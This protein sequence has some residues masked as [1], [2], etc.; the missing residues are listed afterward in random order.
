[1]KTSPLIQRFTALV[2][3]WNAAGLGEQI[4]WEVLEGLRERPFPFLPPLPEEDLEMC[5]A[6]RDDLKMWPFWDEENK[7]WLTVPISSWRLIRTTTDSRQLSYAMEAKH[8][9]GRHA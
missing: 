5:R 7:V 1:M 2:D 9:Q 6:L 4:L 8:H 3:S